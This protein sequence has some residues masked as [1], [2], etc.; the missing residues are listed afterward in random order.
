MESKESKRGG[1]GERTRTQA[2]VGGN[3]HPLDVETDG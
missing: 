3:R 2:N 1:H